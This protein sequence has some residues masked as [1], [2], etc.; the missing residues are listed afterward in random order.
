MQDPIGSFERIRELYISYLDTAF[1]IGDPSVAAERRAL[2]RE[3]GSLCTQPLIEPIPRYESFS[4]HFHDWVR[5][6]AD[7]P[8][9]GFPDHARRAFLKLVVSGLFPS[10]A[11]DASPLG[12]VARFKPYRHQVEMLRRGIRVGTPGIVTTGTGSGKTEA[13]LLPLLAAISREA[14]GWTAPRDDF[15]TRRWWHDDTGR[16]FRKL[17]RKGEEVITYSAIP[18]ERRPTKTTPL[19]SPVVPQRS[20]ETRPS[21]MRALVLY[22]MNAL[23]EDQM[24]RLRKALDSAEARAVMDQEFKGNR[25]FFGRYTSQTPVTGHA[26]HPGLRRLLST[27]PGEATLYYPDH[28]KADAEGY[29]ALADIRDE[30]IAKRQRTLQKLFDAMV[31]IEDGQRQARLHALDRRAATRFD[32]IIREREAIGAPIM[33]EEFVALAGGAGKRRSGALE[34]LFEVRFGSRPSGAQARELDR[35]ALSAMDAQTAASFDGD[36]APFLFPSVDGSEVVSRWDMQEHPPDILITNVSMLSAMLNREVDEPIFAKT[37]EWLEGDPNAYFYLV[38]DELHLQRGSAGTEVACLLRLLLHRL[39]LARPEHRHKIRVLA[40]SASLPDDP[41]TEAERSADY[42]WDMFGHFGLEGAALDAEAGKRQ[43][44]T[45]IRCGKGA[46]LPP[47]YAGS[48]PPSLLPTSPF[49]DVLR[50]SVVPEVVASDRPLASPASARFPEPGSAIERVWLEVARALVLGNDGSCAELIREAIREAAE[51]LVW[52]CWEHDPGHEVR[53]RVRA[54]PLDQVGARL[55]S[56]YAALPA[57]ARDECIRGLLFVR[58]VADGMGDSLGRF[59]TPPPSFRIHTFFRSIEGLYAPAGRLLGRNPGLDDGREVEV[60]RLTIEREPRL[61]IVETD[62]AVASYRLFELLYCEACGDLFFGGLK[63]NVPGSPYAAELLPHEP[64]LDGLPDNAASQR[65]EDQ[66]FE[67]YGVFW[68]RGD[69]SPVPDDDVGDTG[70]AP[71]IAAY[72]ER[73]TGGIRKLGGPGRLTADEV[74]KRP[75]MLLGW[76]FDYDSNANREFHKR[77]KSSG[78]THVPYGCP[79]CGTSYARRRDGRLSPIRN[80]RAGFGK[81]TQILATELFDAQRV[82]NPSVSAK[83]VSFSDSR[84]DAAKGALSIERNHHQ[85]VRRIVLARTLR[86]ALGNKPQPETVRAEIARSEKTIRILRENDLHDKANDE[87]TKLTELQSRLVYSQDPTV[88]LS[89]V[90]EKPTVEYL[91]RASVVLPFISAMV[92]QGI[93]PFDEAGVSWVK[94]K[95]GQDERYFDWGTLFTPGEG[96]RI[97]WTPDIRSI[98]FTTTARQELVKR[99]YE[100]LVDV[101][102]SKTYFSFEESG[103]GYVTVPR[104]ATASW[105]QSRISE[106][107]AILRVMADAYRFDPNP[108]AR[109]DQDDMKAWTRFAEVSRRLKNF[110]M[111]S[112]NANA[113]VNLERALADLARVGHMNGIIHVAA[114]A[115]RLVTGDDEYLRCRVCGRVHLHRGTGRCT[116]CCRELPASTT[117]PVSELHDRNFLARRATR[118]SAAVVNDPG[119][120]LH[121]E[122]LTGQT[123]D[124]AKRQREFKGI[125]VPTWEASGEESDEDIDDELSRPEAAAED[126]KRKARAEIDLLTVT[127]TMEVG[128]DI[129]P[130]QAV[131]Q[132]NMPPQRFNYQQRVGRAGRRGQAFSMALTICRTKSHDLHYFRDTKRITGDI[133]PTPFLTKDMPDIPMRFLRKAWLAHAFC[134]ARSDVRASGQIYVT[135]LMS[136]P[137]IHGEYLPTCLWPEGGGTDWRSVLRDRLLDTEPFKN[138]IAI[139]L[140]GAAGVSPDRLEIDSARLLREIDD[141]LVQSRQDGLAHSVAERGWLPMYGMPTRVRDLYLKLD[142]EEEGSRR[143]EWTT[144]DR[145]LDLAIYEF[146]PGAT[147]VVDKREHRAVGFTPSLSPPIRIKGGWVVK[148]FQEDA[149]GETFQLLECGRCHSWARPAADVTET[150]CATCGAPMP[151]DRARTCCVPNGFRTDFRPR[152]RPED[153][154]GGTRHRSIQAEGEELNLRAVRMAG[155]EFEAILEIDFKPTSRTFRLNRGPQTPN[156]REFVALRGDQVGF[157][158]P[159]RVLEGQVVAVDEVSRVNGFQPSTPVPAFWL[160]APKTTNAV[161]LKPT[162]N[163]TGLALYRLPARSDGQPDEA[164]ERWQ[165]VRAAA[166][167]AAYL[168]ATRASDDLDI[169]PE[170]FDIL[171]PRVHGGDSRLPLIEITDHLVNGA[172]FSSRLSQPGSGE[173]PWVL[174]LITSMLEDPTQF[175]RKTF[176]SP[177]HVGGGRACDTACYLCLLRYGNQPFHGLLDWQLGLVFLRSMVD[178]GFRCGLDGVFSVP[179]LHAWPAL[180]RRTAKEM[181]FRFEGEERLFGDV[182]AFRVKV[183]RGLSR[184]VLVAHPLWDWTDSDGPIGNTIL[185]QAFD[186]AAKDDDRSPICWDTFNLTRRQVLVRER[187]RRRGD[188]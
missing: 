99:V 148:A 93:H 49:R 83:L 152:V 179:G 111:A 71:W 85:D 170:E 98:D 6:S 68:S 100:A 123:S 61:E 5:T 70:S 43:W 161:F 58:G 101:V 34:E 94:G 64:I 45:A 159:V 57:S 163:P 42:L 52:A 84:Q 173:S 66:S 154:G 78:G 86:E 81:T 119:F 165:G 19:R 75:D 181:A 9:S 17:N 131:L 7:D 151:S 3:P 105:E 156:G 174:E 63:S 122:E 178:P 106:L 157:P 79:S 62:G 82:A 102:F 158:R 28:R 37:K 92:R 48:S 25:I 33:P 80:F 51:R 59:D 145:D 50:L 120:R 126:A 108:Y 130:L 30:E 87:E 160:A 171:E 112:W 143:Y 168:I 155:R 27:D 184:W 74:K 117:G 162:S 132:A 11:S 39:G 107:S 97:L 89:D 21:A 109:G 136:P 146:A 2:L 53:G 139:V 150:I 188:T 164:T 138:E 113:E 135:D 13:F 36:D 4:S 176:E 172:G 144:I 96:A 175:P 95:D 77:K 134:R 110:A 103:L 12:R 91:A 147:V 1:R 142:R 177:K 54:Q 88:R 73:R 133:P 44:L 24:V 67:A 186:A 90:V 72:L 183:A 23:V 76:L 22:P 10:D 187:V 104:N 185:A 60:G 141:A 26:D 31:D 40:S 180:A 129:G 46:Q 18:R 16:P 56:D 124:P 140:A 114:V 32:R 125:F 167:S 38:L 166:L 55:F 14:V 47:K 182:P 169:D 149:L 8:L 116:R 69:R 118:K 41:P 35:L 15:L 121:C 20:G 153:S 29:V 127:T 115:I 65:F 137:D 128:I